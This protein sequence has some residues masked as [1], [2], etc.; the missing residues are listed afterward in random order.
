MCCEACR[1]DLEPDAPINRVAL[2]Y[3]HPLANGSSA[4]IFRVCAVCSR[5]PNM[6]VEEWWPPLPCIH[7]GR[8]IVASRNR[9]LPKTLLLLD[10]VRCC[11]AKGCC[12]TQAKRA[13]SLHEANLLLHG[14]RKAVPTE[15]HR[16]GILLARVQTAR[17]SSTP[18]GLS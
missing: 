18:C 4:C 1:E 17:L 10:R 2:H 3:S 14:L 9:R 5:S 6:C 13:A 11:S 16:C 15:A 7:C 8:P 12:S